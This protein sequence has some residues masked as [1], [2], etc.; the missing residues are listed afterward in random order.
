MVAKKA[1]EFPTY[2]P[3][4][5]EI[6]MGSA[7]VQAAIALDLAGKYAAET[8]NIEQLT[9]IAAVWMEMGSRLNPQGSDEDELE[10]GDVAGGT[11]DYPLGFASPAANAEARRKREE[12]TNGK[13]TSNR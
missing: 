13:H 10:E 3:I 6:S 12:Q 4:G 7:F 8:Q 9:N 5:D 11:E 1:P 2:T